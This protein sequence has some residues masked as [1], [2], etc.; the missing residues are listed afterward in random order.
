MRN[1]SPEN[2]PSL[3]GTI[4]LVSSELKIWLRAAQT[5]PRETLKVVIQT[6]TELITERDA[7]TGLTNVAIMYTNLRT[8]L[9]QSV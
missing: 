8:A 3:F 4:H 6:A 1:S 9:N 5:R 2:T 7:K